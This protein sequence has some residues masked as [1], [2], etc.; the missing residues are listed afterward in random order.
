MGKDISWPQ[1]PVGLPAPG[2]FGI[3]GVTGGRPYTV[4]PCLTSQ[5]EWAEATPGGAGFYMNTANPGGYALALD[6][7]AQLA[8]DAACQPGNDG[9]C[10]YNFGYN[11]AAEAFAY[12]QSS[13]GA[14]AGRVW[15]LDI[16]LD[17]SWSDTD[18]VANR[19]ALQGNLDFLQSQPGVIVGVYTTPR[20]WHWIMGDYS[21]P[22]PVWMAGAVT[23]EEAIAHCG[24]EYSATGGPVVLSQWVEDVD[25]DHVCA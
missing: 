21:L 9:A 19:A 3:V 24:P 20:M 2:E 16:E 4:N 23:L 12:A 22:L 25:H 17:N 18:I 15:W 11:A 6:W 5:F 13:T 8:P 1:C 7:Y 14:S 10:A